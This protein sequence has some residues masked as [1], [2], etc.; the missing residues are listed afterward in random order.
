M[1]RCPQ[2]DLLTN[3]I[4]LQ[5]KVQKKLSDALDIHG[6]SLTEY[7]VLQELEVAPDH[8]LRRVDL[9]DK[10]GL[11]AS[12]ITRL[13]N[14]MEKIGL[15]AKQEN[16]RD[17]RVSLVTLTKAGAQTYQDA[18]TAFDYSAKAFLASLDVRQRKGLQDAVK[19]LG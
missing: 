10:V 17:A 11:S 8:K 2:S 15:V 16:A 7:L 14:P 18:T 19:A 3:L 13:I 12:G 6:I 4:H 1:S 9:A 5:T